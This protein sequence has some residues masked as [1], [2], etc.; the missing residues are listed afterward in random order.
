M[1]GDTLVKTFTVTHINKH[2]NKL[3]K[4]ISRDIIQKLLGDIVPDYESRVGSFVIDINVTCNPTEEKQNE[5][6]S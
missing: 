5:I 6:G 4:E 1:E 2:L 3:D